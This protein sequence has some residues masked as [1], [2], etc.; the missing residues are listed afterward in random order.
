MDVNYNWGHCL[1]FLL[2]KLTFQNVPFMI[3]IKIKQ[4]MVWQRNNLD[5]KPQQRDKT[6]KDLTKLQQR[7]VL[8][9]YNKDKTKKGPTKEQSGHKTTTKIKQRNNLDTKPQRKDKGN[10]GLTNLQSGYKSTTKIKQT[11]PDKGTKPQHEYKTKVPSSWIWIQNH[12]IK[13]HNDKTNKSLTK[14]QYGYKTTT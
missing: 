7:K 8:Q 12:N 1:K 13:R 6:K 10:K 9:S 5:T 2:L 4:V 3:N 11:L 14:K